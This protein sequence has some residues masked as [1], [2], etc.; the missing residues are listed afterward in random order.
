M[1]IYDWFTQIVDKTYT[2]RRFK[3]TEEEEA[4]L[5]EI[6]N[7]IEFDK[8]F[9]MNKADLW[10][11]YGVLPHNRKGLTLQDFFPTNEQIETVKGMCNL[12]ILTTEELTRR[13]MSYRSKYEMDLI[14]ECEQL[15]EQLSKVDHNRAHLN[16]MM[17][18]VK[19]R[20]KT[21]EQLDQMDKMAK[22]IQTLEDTIERMK[23]KIP[24]TQLEYLDENGID[25]SVTYAPALENLITTTTERMHV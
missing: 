22:K 12:H 18:L 1:H 10:L 23:T 14:L 6:F 25:H 24:K 9:S 5:V 20:Q 15:R 21:G 3:K 17:E 11:T 2:L 19:E 7:A 13:C 4:L 8:N 16:T